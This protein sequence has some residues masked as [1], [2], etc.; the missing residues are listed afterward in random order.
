MGEGTEEEVVLEEFQHTDAQSRR[1]CE[2]KALE[3]VEAAVSASESTIRCAVAIVTV[4]TSLN[5][6]SILRHE[7]NGTEIGNDLCL[8]EEE[9][10]VFGTDHPKSENGSLGVAEAGNE[11]CHSEVVA[12]AVEAEVVAVAAEANLK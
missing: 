3:I 2:L 6:T 11:S 10:A 5:T 12:V 8:E 7:K 4:I 9:G 1:N